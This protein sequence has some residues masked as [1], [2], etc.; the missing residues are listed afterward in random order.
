MKQPILIGLSLALLMPSANSMAEENPA[1]EPMQEYLEFAAFS[2]GAITK[3]QLANFS[4]DDI[5]YIDTRQA[6]QF[7]TSHIPGAINIDWRQ[8]LTHKDQISDSKTVV[9]YCDT[10]LLSSKA[11][12]ALSVLGYENVRVLFGG[13]AEWIK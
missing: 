8:I 1:F 13:Y 3:Q 9:L 4:S 12:F 10:G 7:E 6:E 5:Q 11:Q 2:G